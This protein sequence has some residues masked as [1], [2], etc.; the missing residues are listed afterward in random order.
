[1]DS[2][3]TTFYLRNSLRLRLKAAAIKWN[4]AV[5]DLLT[6]GAEL[7][8]ARY[9]N[10]ADQEELRRRAAKAREQLRRGLYSGPSVADAADA[11]LYL[12]ERPV[13]LRTKKS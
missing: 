3:K 12:G 4:K 8:L 13:R 7:V 9:D 6:E 5:T 11:I 10:R 2:T 1:M